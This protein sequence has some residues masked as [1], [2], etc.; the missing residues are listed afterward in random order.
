LQAKAKAH[1]EKLFEEARGKAQQELIEI[2]AKTQGAEQ[3]YDRLRKGVTQ[4]R[5]TLL[6]IVEQIPAGEGEAL[7]E[8]EPKFALPEMEPELDFLNKSE[9]MFS[10]LTSTWEEV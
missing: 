7:P 10:D 8:P 3:E 2:S 6:G 9:D 5:A 1:A 4:L